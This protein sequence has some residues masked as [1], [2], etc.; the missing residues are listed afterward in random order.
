MTCIPLRLAL[1]LVAIW[2]SLV[3]QDGYVVGGELWIGLFAG[4]DSDLS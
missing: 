4:T 1:S 3:E 2:I